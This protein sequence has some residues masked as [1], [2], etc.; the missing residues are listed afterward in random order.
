MTSK[1]VCYFDYEVC[2]DSASMSLTVN[3]LWVYF[4]V[5]L[6]CFSCLF[7]ISISCF[8]KVTFEPEKATACRNLLR[9]QMTFGADRS[10][11]E[12]RPLFHFG[13]SITNSVDGMI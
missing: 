6:F 3:I 9:I 7:I 13:D 1:S 12:I 5:V 10:S 4:V 11:E 8:I 2:R